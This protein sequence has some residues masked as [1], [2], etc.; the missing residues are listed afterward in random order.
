MEPQYRW[1]RADE[2]DE[3]YCCPNHEEK[4]IYYART[5]TPHGGFGHSQTNSLIL[6]FKKGP[7][8]PPNEL[9]YRKE[10]IEKFASEVTTF[11]SAGFGLNNNHLLIPMP[12][13]KPNQS[14]GYD[15]RLDLVMQKLCVACKNVK[16]FPVLKRIYEVP[17]S[18]QST[19]TRNAQTI[20][21]SLGIDDSVASIYCEG[22]ILTILDDI[23]TSGAHF[24]AARR[25]LEEKFSGGRIIGVFWAKSKPAPDDTHDNPTFS[26]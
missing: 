21:D 13:S 3:F 26:D 8:K 16:P 20:Y 2:T 14:S 4:E 17:A 7:N 12:T 6:N 15:N 22:Q 10:A 24:E 5:Y 11:L 18:H 25:H 23:T 19:S 1:H 9:Y